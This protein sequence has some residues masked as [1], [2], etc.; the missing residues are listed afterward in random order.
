MTNGPQAD[1]SP[2]DVPEVSSRLF[3]PRPE[4]P[5]AR[6]MGTFTDVLI[7]VADGVVVGGRF[8][9]DNKTS[10]NILF[11]HGNGEIV[12]DYDDFGGIYAG[13][14]MNFFAVDYRGYG[15]STG[16]PTVSSM[17]ADCRVVFRFVKAW[18]KENGHTGPTIVMGRSLGSASALE[19]ASCCM[20]ELDGL[21]IESGFTYLTPLLDLLGVDTDAV[22]FIEEDF[23][24][25]LEKISSFRKPTLIIHAE[26]DH[27]IPFADGEALYEA[28]AATDKTLLGIPKAN[29]NDIFSRA[30]PEYM[31]EVKLLARRVEAEC[32]RGVPPAPPASAP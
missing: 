31:A 11:F 32:A 30:L 15:R 16:S 23:M 5:Q 20:D 25:N 7:P 28:C 17:M 12:A 29:H 3:H 10:P 8:H 27:I 2:L 1:Y 4:P 13:M 21:I 6:S 26:W 14:Q 24:S 18:L 19:L 22:G 9:I